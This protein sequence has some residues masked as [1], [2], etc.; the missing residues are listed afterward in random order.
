MHCSNYF[1]CLN[2]HIVFIYSGMVHVSVITHIYSVYHPLS[3]GWKF[4]KTKA[5]LKVVY[6]ET[7]YITFLVPL[8][9]A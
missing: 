2:Q 4:V 5:F 3:G 6:K 7:V 1:L 8:L 9:L